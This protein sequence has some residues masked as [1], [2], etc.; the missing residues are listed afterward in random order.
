MR[1]GCACSRFARIRHAVMATA[2]CDIESFRAVPSADQCSAARRRFQFSRRRN[3]CLTHDDVTPG[4][5]D[6]ADVNNREAAIC[7]D[8]AA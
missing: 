4:A 3:R 7:W 5:R 6:A 2:V 1:L 8:G